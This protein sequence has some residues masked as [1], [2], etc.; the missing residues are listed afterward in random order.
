M[1]LNKSCCHKAIEMM[2]R[3]S[4]KPT[5]SFTYV[6]AKPTNSFT[7]AVP[8][9]CYPKRS[10]NNIPKNIADRLRRICDLD[11]KFDM[12]SNEYQNYLIVRDY[13]I[14]LV[15]K[16]V[17]F[18]K[19]IC[20]NEARQLKRKVTKEFQHGYNKIAVYGKSLW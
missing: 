14:C 7:Y 6:Y 4:N 19:S 20:R 10:I 13:S 12:R 3:A 15:K 16:P 17:H 5:N 18:A 8:S 11:G 2:S 9:T 1:I